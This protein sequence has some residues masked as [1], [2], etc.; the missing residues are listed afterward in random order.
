MPHYT[1][2]FALIIISTAVLLTVF[3]R[4]KDKR[5]VVLLFFIIGMAYVLEYVVFVL[6]ESYEYDPDFMTNEYF[7]NLF[8]SLTSQTFAFP[9]M[10]M[11]V[12]AY[13][14]KFRYILII[15][16][17]FMGIEELFLHWDIYTHHWWKTIYT[18]VLMTIGFSIS[19]IWY[20]WLTERYMTFVH[21][22]TFFLG[23]LAITSTIMFLLLAYFHNNWFY[24]GWFASAT[25]DS[26]NATMIYVCIVTILLVWS[27]VKEFF[28]GA[29]IIIAGLRIVDILL[30]HYG[31]LLVSITTSLV[32]FT[33][34]QAGVFILSVMLQNFIMKNCYGT[35]KK[36]VAFPAKN[37]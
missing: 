20:V 28:I 22:A 36:D 11:V 1:A 13:Q 37:Y 3:I 6:F 24:T 31:I 35:S 15:S 5:L 25:H 12:A 26:V 10:A 18:G 29:G 7:D 23:M 16:A 17:M 14:L 21:Y 27:V 34:L 19:K 33:L 32:L 4:K 30:I 9:I 2:F 8:G